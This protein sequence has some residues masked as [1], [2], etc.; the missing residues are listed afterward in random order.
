[1][2]YLV[3]YGFAVIAAFGV[4][5]LVRDEDGEATHLSRWAGLG[6]RAPLV[7]GI[8]TLLL[9][10]FAGIPLT[11]GFVSKF[12]V[13]SAALDVEGGWQIAMVIVGVVTSMILAFPYLREI[14]MMNLSEPAEQS[15]TVAIPGFIAALMLGGGGVAMACYDRCSM[16]ASRASEF[17]R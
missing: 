17:I 14:D 5:T 12:G 9:L 16:I 11:S 15:P 6:K 2:F 13:F 10:A 1:M 3:A 7:G 4:V 8:F